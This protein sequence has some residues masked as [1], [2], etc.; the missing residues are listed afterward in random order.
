MAN[1]M[2]GGRDFGTQDAF[3]GGGRRCGTS[4][5]NDFQ[6]ARIRAHMATFDTAGAAEVG[7]IEV[8]VVFHVI[9]SGAQGNL[10]D[11]KLDEQLAVLNDCFRPHAIH[12][13]RVGVTRTDNP[14][15]FKMTMTSAAER[16]AKTALCVDS[17]RHLNFY[18]AAI[19]AGL[20]GWATFPSE[21]SADPKMD[22]VVVLHSTLP[23]GAS[24]P[25]DLGKT[26][27]HE[28]GHWL[29]LYHTFEGGCQPPG[30]EVADT[31]SEARPNSGPADPTRDTC[32]GGGPDPVTNYMDYTDD[33]GMVE[34]TPGQAQ[35]IRQQVNL[36]R[37]AL[38]GAQDAVFAA[39]R[40][41]IDHE[42]GDF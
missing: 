19:G 11:A 21:L 9:H 20:L 38:L 16:K 3:I 39:A 24:A 6:K 12:F 23:G 18:T 32:P 33:S 25:Y 1:F 30:D 31:P 8:P 22:G 35:R 4:A 41:A 17:T 34:F 28:V 40:V 10:S 37:S 26:A 36:Y 27:V 29:G 2:I 15:W 14:S 42:T 7:P 5:L 13:T